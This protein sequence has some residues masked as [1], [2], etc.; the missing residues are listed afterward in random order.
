MANDSQNKM[1]EFPP[2]HNQDGDHAD[3]IE[4]LE[5]LLEA[6]QAKI[7]ERLGEI[8]MRLGLG[9]AK[10]PDPMHASQWDMPL[11]WHFVHLSESLHT[12]RNSSHVLVGRIEELSSKL[13]T[14]AGIGRENHKAITDLVESSRLIAISARRIEETFPVVVRD[15]P[16]LMRNI[17]WLDTNPTEIWLILYSGGEAMVFAMGGDLL[18]RSAMYQSMSTLITSNNIWGLICGFLSFLGMSAFASRKKWARTAIA[19]ANVVYFGTTGFLT[20]WNAASVLGW[21]PHILAGV[22]AFWVLGRGPSRA[23]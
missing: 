23:I 1:S 3:R 11:N 7:D 8:S 19:F 22:F 2:D 17:W 10:P 15:Q 5:A 16:L 9:A 13:D 21:L 14:N 4:K 20:L 18:I 6:T 12:L